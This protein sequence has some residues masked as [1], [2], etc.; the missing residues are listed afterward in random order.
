MPHLEFTAGDGLY[1]TFIYNYL[2]QGS[3][4]RNKDTVSLVFLFH[5]RPCLPFRSHHSL[6]SVWAHYKALSRVFEEM[7]ASLTKCQ[8]SQVLALSH[9]LGGLYWVMNAK[10]MT[11]KSFILDNFFSGSLFCC[12]WSFPVNSFPSAHLDC[13]YIHH[14]LP[15]MYSHMHTYTH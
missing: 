15:S 10:A 3:A 13:P 1:M 11:L 8:P 12:H 9:S 7:I 2:W 14:R 6:R 5:N 4:E